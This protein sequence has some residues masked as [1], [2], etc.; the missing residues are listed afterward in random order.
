M[1]DGKSMCKETKEKEHIT[2]RTG[3]SFL[4]GRGGEQC[5]KAEG[6]GKQSLF[7]SLQSVSCP[8]LALVPSICSLLLNFRPSPTLCMSVGISNSRNT[9][10]C[11]YCCGKWHQHLLS[12]L[13]QKFRFDP[14]HS[15][16]LYCRYPPPP[17]N[18]FF[19]NAFLTH[20]F[21]FIFTATTFV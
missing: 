17:S 14:C 2:E 15:S 6:V 21:F 5:C 3:S 20:M 12:Y 13:C 10:S 11:V 19:P 1:P 8:P 4:R 18:Q 7:M 16:L 9:F